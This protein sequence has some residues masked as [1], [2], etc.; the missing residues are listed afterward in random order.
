[1]TEVVEVV[2]STSKSSK[3]SSYP[4]KRK[5]PLSFNQRKRNE[6]IFYAKS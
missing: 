6:K 1:M 5:H 4:K 3:I 2:A